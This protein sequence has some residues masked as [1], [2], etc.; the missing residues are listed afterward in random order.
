MN[1]IIK[2]ENPGYP[3]EYHEGMTFLNGD[4]VSAR[5]QSRDKARRISRPQIANQVVKILKSK[6]PNAKISIITA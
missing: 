6:L 5:T 2:I 1:K 3:V 4:Y